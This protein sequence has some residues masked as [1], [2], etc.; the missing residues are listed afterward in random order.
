MPPTPQCS[1][2][3]VAAELRDALALAAEYLPP[4]THPF[5]LIRLNVI[6]RMILWST[7]QEILAA[8]WARIVNSAEAAAAAGTPPRQLA[9]QVRSN[10]PVR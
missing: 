1:A 7:E 5:Y 8:E 4:D 3:T 6:D 10:A 9:P 2:L